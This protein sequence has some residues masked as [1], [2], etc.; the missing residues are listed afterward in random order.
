MSNPSVLTLE[1]VRKIAPSVFA[2]SASPKMSERYLF[3]S[4]ADVIAPLL[5]QG[6]SITQAVQRSTRRN[7]RD[8]NFTRHMLRLRPDGAKPVVG[9]TVPEVVVSN[10]HD[11]QAR[12][13]IHGGLFR[14]VCSNGMVVS[15]GQSYGAGFRHLGDAEKVRDGIREA[16]EGS[17]AI[18]G[19]VQKMT[20]K[21]LTAKQQTRLASSAAELVWDE[22]K[23]TPDLLL[24]ARRDEDKG[25]DLWRVFNRIQENI[26]RGGVRFVSAASNRSFMTRGITHIGRSIDLN[27]GLWDLALA[28]V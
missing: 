11:G 7:G 4:T 27:K 23:F 16:V 14:L 12:F 28:H 8:P 13:V 3:L 24:E 5:S 6:Y 20:K 1:A 25:D 22:Q 2:K 18:L 19:T 9:N 10:A 17:K 21:N 26:V 15:M